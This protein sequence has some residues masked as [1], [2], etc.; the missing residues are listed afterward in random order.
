M[1]GANIS[2]P[3]VIRIFRRRLAAF[4]QTCSA[5]LGGSAG[6]FVRVQDWL[7]SDQQGHWK[8]QIAKR[9]ELYQAARRT[10]LDAEAEVRA[11]HNSRGIDKQSSMEERL[12]MERARRSR[13]EAEEKLAVVRRWLIRLGQECGPLIHQCRDH[14]LALHDM[15]DKAVARLDQLADRVETYL[16]LPSSIAPV[17]GSSSST[18]PVQGGGAACPP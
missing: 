13:D 14:D 1:S 15:S 2:D 7:Q 17:A 10:W 16:A 18:S 8:K 4:Q 5:A 3:E 6:D 9:E 12:L 11:S